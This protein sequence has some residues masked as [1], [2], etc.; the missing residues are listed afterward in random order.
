MP[1]LYDALRTDNVAL[2]WNSSLKKERTKLASFW[3]SSRVC[4]K[5]SA[6]LGEVSHS[7]ARVSPGKCRDSNFDEG[8]KIN[9]SPFTICFP[10]HS[11]L[12]NLSI[13]RSIAEF[14]GDRKSSLLESEGQTG[15]QGRN[16]YS[17]AGLCALSCRDLGVKVLCI[18]R[19]F[20]DVNRLKHSL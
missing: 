4:G 17:L 19:V 13:E 1:S 18:L 12:H 5:F 2:T 7:F 10:F 11:I 9:S 16:V 15:S 20:R 14:W 3:P 8:T 6:I